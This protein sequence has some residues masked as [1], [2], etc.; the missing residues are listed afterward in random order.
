M[1]FGHSPKT[2]TTN[3]PLSGG[4]STDLETANTMKFAE[5]I[6]N[7]DKLDARAHD[8]FFLLIQVWLDSLLSNIE[9]GENKP[10]EMASLL[11]VESQ[12]VLLLR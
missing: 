11:R 2:L 10:I 9:K 3:M 8:N 1:A 12:A 4:L 6:E 7:A 5:L